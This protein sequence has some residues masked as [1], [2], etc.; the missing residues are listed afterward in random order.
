MEVEDAGKSLQIFTW[1]IDLVEAKVWHNVEILY[2][3]QLS[4]YSWENGFK[5]CIVF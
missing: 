4:K 1:I 3:K 2:W 5:M